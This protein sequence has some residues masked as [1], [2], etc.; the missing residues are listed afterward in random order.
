MNLLSQTW[1]GWIP[2]EDRSRR[3]RI[4]REMEQGVRQGVETR[5]LAD[6][7]DPRYRAATIQLNAD[8]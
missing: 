3:T 7:R 5:L 4:G 6:Q 8:A 2:A 1:L